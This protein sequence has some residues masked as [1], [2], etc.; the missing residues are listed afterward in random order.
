MT[1]IVVTSHSQSTYQLM[2]A[3]T[4]TRGQLARGVR[5]HHE[6]SNPRI[7][8]RIPSCR[9][10]RAAAVGSRAMPNHES[11]SGTSALVTGGASGM[12]EATARRL[13]AAG[14]TVV[15]VDRDQAKGE[16]VAAELDGTL[17]AGRRDQRG[18]RHGRGRGRDARSRRCARAS[19]APASAGRNARSTGPATRIRSRR[20][21]RSSRSTS[22]ARSTCCGSRR[23]A[24][25]ATSPTSN[26][27]R[28]VI[29]NTASIAALRRP[30]RPGRVLGVEGRRRRAHA[31]PRP[32]TS[33]RSGS[34]CA[35]SRPGSSTRPL[36]GGLPADARDALAQSVLFPKRLGVPD[37]FASLAMEIVRNGYLNGEVIRM[38]AGIR[39]PPSNGESRPSR[40]CG[41]VRA[42]RRT[43]P[44]T[45][46]TCSTAAS[47][48][49]T[50]TRSTRGCA[51]NAPVYFDA[52]NGVWG[53]AVV[54]RAARDG[55]GPDDVL[56]R[57]R[58]PARQR[59][60]PDDDRHGRSGALE[61]P[62]AREQGLHARAACATASR[63]S[64]TR[65][66]RSSTRCASGAS[67]TSST[68]SPR[69]CR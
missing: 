21:A 16:Q 3:S 15:I 54:R 8:P 24:C 29:V 25:R 55:E 56:E 44:A 17:R 33:P 4:S 41:R 50:R 27:E 51:S 6:E 57:G 35:R 37:D 10:V 11:L 67:A 23:R 49:T 22:S 68:T 58:H 66:T 61:A 19:T 30:D 39:M 43:R 38:D 47:T 59:P 2:T 63:R 1:S 48:S 40:A 5:R 18:R 28:G 45:T 14:A 7:G 42:W 46:S 36:L 13:A 12:G 53:I 9:R 26:G 32:A 65:A 69:R 20:S 60:D 64:A 52:K 31:R 62:Q 34:G